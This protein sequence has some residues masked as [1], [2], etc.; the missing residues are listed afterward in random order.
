M[1]MKAK[2]GFQKGT[3]PSFSPLSMSRS[4]QTALSESEFNSI[5]R[6]PSNVSNS[7]SDGTES[8]GPREQVMS[9]LRRY[10][11]KKRSTAEKNVSLGVLQQYFFGSL[12]DAAKSIGVCPTTLKRICRQHGI[13]RWPSRKINKVNRSL[14]KIQTV[15]DSVQGMEGGLKFDP[16]TG[17]FVAAGSIIQEFDA[18]KKTLF[19]DKN[20]PVKNP[21]PIIQDA[22]SIP[23]ALC[24][25][26]EKSAVKQE[27]DECSSDK[28]QVGP[29]KSMI[30]PNSSEGDVHR[31]NVFLIDCTEDSMLGGIDA[32]Q[33]QPAKLGAAAWVTP[34]NGSYGSLAVAEVMDTKMEGYDGM[35]EQNQPT[36]SGMTDSSNGS[37]VHGSSS[38][39]PSSEE[40]KQSKVQPSCSGN[41][42]KITVKATYKEDIIRFK[43]EPTA[44]FLQLYEEVASRLKLQNGTFQLKYLDDEEEWVMLVS[45][46]DLQEC[47][48]I[49]ESIG[50]RSVKFLVRDLSSAVGSSGSSNCFL[51]CGS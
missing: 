25:D 24:M 3:V 14:K 7:K 5:D 28:N 39:S 17:G 29:G 50:T 11:E 2:V 27:E 36:F 20:L 38:S 46:L 26:E 35:I 21:E 48:E 15:L 32:G 4:S 51:V 34:E 47:L 9:G 19:P 45:D 43:F 18:R 12:K 37:L 23:P 10:S 42:T 6:M 13:S 44:G 16:T 41:G 40:G 1:G 22:A 49:M 31:S 33:F 30:I 8:D